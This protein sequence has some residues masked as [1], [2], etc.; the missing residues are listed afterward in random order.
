MKYAGIIVDNNTSATDALYTY[1]TELEDIAV[2]QKVIVPFT[3]HDRRAEGYVATL[4]DEAPEGLSRIKDIIEIV[5]GVQ[6]SEEAVKTA[7]WMHDR[8]LCRYIEAVKCFLPVSEAKRRT[9][10]PFA[11]LE[12]EP[13]EPK[14][15]TKAQAAA[16]SE[17]NSAV[18]AKK[19]TVSS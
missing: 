18:E 12:C 16:L 17:I 8:F 19:N 7:M 13:T 2:G 9:K 5:P 15:L 6:L 1:R 3:M 10:D 11:D 4:S 14:E